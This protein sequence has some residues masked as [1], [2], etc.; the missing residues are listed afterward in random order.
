MFKPP[1]I[2]VL[3]IVSVIAGLG[4]GALALPFLAD[5]ARNTTAHKLL[6]EVVERA[7]SRHALFDALTAK[8]RAAIDSFRRRYAKLGQDEAD[9]IF[10]TAFPEHPSGVRRSRP[11]DYDG[12]VREGGVR[13]YGVGAFIGETDPD[14]RTRRA[15]A[16]AYLTVREVGPAYVE[17]FDTLY[18]ADRRNLVMFA[19]NRED[20]LMFYRENAPAD[21]RWDQH[22]MFRIV[23]PENNPLGR[24]AC[25]GLTDLVYT[26]EARVQ[27]LSCH[28]PIRINGVHLGAFGDTLDVAGVLREAVSGLDRHTD[29]LVITQ[30]GAAVAHP[31]LF[32]EAVITN[33]DVR[34]VA[35]AHGFAAL[36]RMVAARGQGAGVFTPPG[37]GLVAYAR[38]D[39]PGWFLVLKRDA[40]VMS[41]WT[42]LKAGGVGA[43]IAVL[44]FL[45]LALMVEARDRRRAWSRATI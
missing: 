22:Q 24:T 21:F 45:Q 13:T 2:V 12:V 8:H 44:V 7:E 36:G 14:A 11:E 19:P 39:A 1:R 37:G 15:L 9:R 31:V 20:R 6:V 43:L 38:L 28:T 30:E 10:E 16:A 32:G 34:R 41:V 29:A 3:A 25:T 4:A 5:E 33:E 23:Q 18:F 42:G 40:G 17:Q 35:E 26:E 27:S